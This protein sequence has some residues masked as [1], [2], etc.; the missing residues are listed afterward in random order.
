MARPPTESL[1]HHKVETSEAAAAGHAAAERLAHDWENRDWVP[2]APTVGW[3]RAAVARLGEIMAEQPSIL[4]ASKEGANKGAGTLSPRPFQGLVECLQNADDLGATVLHVAYRAGPRP[5]LLI[6]HN[7]APVT[8]ANVG[9]MLLPWLSTKD[10]DADAS[11][12]FGIGQQTLN[13][14]GSPIAL[15]AS[16]FH[17]VMC[18]DGPELCDP[19][20]S[21]E[22]VYD[23]ARRDTMLTVPLEPTVTRERVIDAV[24]E[25]G[26][27]ALIFLKSIRRLHFHDLEVPA[28]DQTFAVE[29]TP[30]G[31]DTI[32]FGDEEV[33]VAIADVRIVEPT[34]TSSTNWYRCYSTRRSVKAGTKRSNK[35]TGTTTPIAVAVPMGTAHPLRISDRMPLP[36]ATGLTI[37][38]DAQF[39][40]DSAR[41]TLLPNE[42]NEARFAD[43]GQL[44]A[45]SVLR[46]FGTETST[47]WN[48][49]PLTAEVDQ[50]Q[51][52]AATQVRTLVIEACHNTLRSQ[53]KIQTASA[54]AALSDLAYEA[55]E[56]EDLLTEDDVNLLRPD[57][58][59]L[60]RKSRDPSG[61]WRHVLEE[62]NA[63]DVLSVED[64]LEVIDGD[65]NRGSAWYVSF[66][67]LAERCNIINQ[68]VT[69]PSLLLADDTVTAQPSAAD[70]W[71]LV[72]N[73][74]PD[75]LATRL[76]L[77]R[78]IHPAYFEHEV[79]TKEF[80]AKIKSMNLLFENRDAAAD[81]FAI[82]GRGNSAF[83]EGDAAVRLEDAEL[84]ELRD[85]WAH[86]PRERH[87]DLGMKV[88]CR[89][90]LK[91]TWYEENGKRTKGWSRPIDM[92]LPGA[93]DREVDSFAKAAGRTPGLRWADAKYAQI[94]KHK[95]G[96]SAVGA[97]RLLS[98]WGVAREPRLVRPA[99]EVSLWTRDTTP[100]SPLHTRMRTAE[101]LRS[102]RAAGNFTHLIDDRWSP[103]AEAAVTDIARAPVKTRRKRA[104]AFLSLLSR[105]WEK[106]Y[107][108]AI[109]TFPAYAYNGYWNRGT[110]VRATWLARLAAV[111]WMPDAGNGLQCPADL[112]LQLPGS[113]P[114]PGERSNFVT[115]V[116]NHV[117]RSGVLA[118]IGVKAGPTQR[119]LVERLISLR[120]E[121]VTAAVSEEAS[122]TYQLLAASQ[123]D[124]NEGVPEG[125]MTPVQ[126]RNSFRAGRDGIGLLLVNGQ[127]V[128]PETVFRGPAI[129]GTYR[130]FAPHIEGMERLWSTLGVKVPTAVDAINVLR[131]L[132]VTAPS[133]ADLG[134]A[135]RAY[136]LIAGVVT[137]M[138]PQRRAV[139]RRLPL[140]TGK[141]WTIERPVYAL[142]GEVL[143]ASAPA[144]LRVW[145]PGMT[146]FHALKLL[147][148]PLGVEQLNASDFQV[149]SSPA[150]GLAEGEAIRPIFSR[151]VALLRQE[152]VS[153]DQSLF[154]SLTV[155]WDELLNTPV[156]IDPE[157]SIIAK[158]AALPIVLP[159]N[160]HV[161]RNPLRLIV[162][163]AASAG[164]AQGAGAAIASLFDGDRQKAAWAWAAIWPRAVAGELA[165]GA[166]LPKARSEPGNAKERLDRLAKQA[167]KRRGKGGPNGNASIRTQKSGRST[168]PVQVRKLRELDDL[169]PSSGNIVNEGARSAGRF[170]SAKR[171]KGKER[172]FNLKMTGS[173]TEQSKART[174]LPPGTDR[175]KMALEAVRRALQL[176]VQQFN[177]LR[178][179]RGIGVDAI[180]DLRQC[181]EIKMNSGTS[182]PT[183]VTL[184]ASEVE[185]AKNDPDFFL[186][187]VSGLEDG[188]GHLRVRFIFD[189]LSSLDI[190][191]RGDLTL[192]GVDKVE[193]LEFSF[194]RRNETGSGG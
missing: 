146:S 73:A 178:S 92:Y 127:W 161:A 29:V 66:A 48:H 59:A 191:L 129:F 62:L 188:A 49:V 162:R 139:L 114:R 167:A 152:M 40:P 28:R 37:G 168:Q 65:P 84:L 46:A 156:M 119:D 169:E 164:N 174:V 110:E 118:A 25:L 184:T 27:D 105:V 155:E 132:A 170:V 96:R 18:T 120:K 104:T 145:R 45:W 17:F 153:A 87:S 103:D 94:L 141:E 140:W 171:R 19:E 135:M 106:R 172:R 179:A 69:R 57:S 12:R 79:L 154:D 166:V 21:I 24:R 15:H 89:V 54:V 8:L 130:S 98:A 158:P 51:D 83:G 9:A 47:A 75:A 181:Y 32:D 189:P 116:D 76:G 149:V 121:P 128:S 177:D 101:Q 77:A 78:R 68:F 117:L 165:E 11:G 93:I 175:E 193:A 160:A 108:D 42:W 34:A 124:K 5:D 148:E 39:D 133:S 113:P 71:V 70:L 72:E 44:V 90:E 10:A 14:L 30:S 159:V 20:P 52:W 142:E 138:S 61:R 91:A 16:P 26:V 6:V 144:T 74:R 137:E 23:S 41:S 53:L 81:V 36:V 85:A 13:S 157:L 4:R 183:D 97:Q 50:G 60:P 86:L 151:A 58:V 190:R 109:T 112:Q 102:V 163:D 186:A 125:K 176:D 134:V 123:H 185:A 22:G 115:K 3:A 180:D 194:D 88:G 82:L 56:L 55:E 63:S 1:N 192:T 38:L 173:E 7:G 143:H 111:K 99:D 95:A 31:Q 150:Y 67:A 43:L 80:L 107:S 136:T 187:I 131:E 100:T 126:L 182:I 147:L 2:P 35:A 33:A 122:A 64:A